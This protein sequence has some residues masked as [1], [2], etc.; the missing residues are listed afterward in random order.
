MG[1]RARVWK[2]GCLAVLAVHL[3]AR[4]EG[5]FRATFGFV[6]ADF[7][8]PVPF[9]DAPMASDPASG[10]VLVARG[11]DVEVFNE[12]GMQVF[13]LRS[14]YHLATVLDL[15]VEPD[16]QVITLARD[17]DAPGD[18]PR[19]VMTRHDFRGVPL[20]EIEISGAPPPFD[21]LLPNRVFSVENG[22]VFAN[23][24]RMRVVRTRRDGTFEKGLDLA[25]I[26]EIDEEDREA[27]EITGLD[28]DPTGRMLLT[29]AVMFR[30]FEISP[31]GVL[32][33]SWGEAGSARGT[34]GVTAGITRDGRGR[35]YVADKNRGV[36]MVFDP[37][38]R[39]L[40][41]FAGE[42]VHFL[43]LPSRLLVDAAGRLHVTQVGNRGVWVFDI[44]PK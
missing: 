20:A 6:L 33:A 10:E 30:V 13:R 1:S 19:I 41:E 5:E 23:T 35:T 44:R 31:E 28:V 3:G 34:F 17:L 16:G 40:E 24:S 22:L 12:Q 29:C 7:T 8:G 25:E 14:P 11:R 26:L 38:H 9:G 42:G 39:L 15:A 37:A 4:A 18:L 2:L 43:R 32:V 27:V 36:I 21:G